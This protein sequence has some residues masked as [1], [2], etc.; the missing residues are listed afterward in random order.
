[1]SLARFQAAVFFLTKLG[2]KDNFAS[3][4]FGQDEIS[5][6]RCPWVWFFSNGQATRDVCDSAAKVLRC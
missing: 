6:R 1:M 3:K 2:M 5:W 4:G